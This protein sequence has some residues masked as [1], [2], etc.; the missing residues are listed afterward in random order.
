MLMPLP[1]LPPNFFPTGMAL[2]L[3]I[4]LGSVP[5][6]Q[7]A[8]VALASAINNGNGGTFNL[9]PADVY[10]GSASISAA[11]VINANG[12]II[13]FANG[14]DLQVN[15][16]TLTVNNAA[17]QFS[18]GASTGFAVNFAAPA[19]GQMNSC[20]FTGF[21][22]AV[23][24][25][26]ASAIAPVFQG[27][28]FTSNN[29]ALFIGGATRPVA[30]GCTFTNNG[31][32]VQASGTSAP[33]I[34][35]CTFTNTSPAIARRGIQA[36][37]G[38]Y[39]SGQTRI[40]GNTF[41]N[42]GGSGAPVIDLLGTAHPIIEGNSFSYNN[43]QADTWF[44]QARDSAPHI[45]GNRFQ[46]GGR[47]IVIQGV[48]SFPAGGAL[49]PDRRP[50]EGNVF[51]QQTVTSVQF[52]SSEAA[53]A[54]YVTGNTFYNTIQGISLRNVTNTV[55]ISRNTF[56]SYAI[57][58]GNLANSQGVASGI[59]VG[60]SVRTRI[61]ENAVKG[62]YIGIHITDNASADVWGNVV[63]ENWGG[64]IIMDRGATADVAYNTLRKN[65]ADNIYYG[66]SSGTVWGNRCYDG[67]RWPGIT[68]GATGIAAELNS[69]VV[70]LDNLT[71]NNLDQGIAII[72]ASQA[73]LIAGNMSVNEGRAGILVGGGTNV[74]AVADNLTLGSPQGI[75]TSVLVG[76]ETAPNTVFWGNALLDATDF[77]ALFN[78]GGSLMR[79]YNP[80]IHTGIRGIG[81]TRGGRLTVRGGII[82]GI[83]GAGGI[84]THFVSND[85][86]IS[87]LLDNTM[88]GPAAG[89]H[90]SNSSAGFN[91]SSTRDWWGAANGPNPPGS[92]F[93]VQRLTVTTPV[94][95]P[96][97]DI[98]R[99]SPLSWASGATTNYTASF[100][101]LQNVQGSQEIRFSS[102]PSL[103]G[104][105]RPF[106]A[107]R[108]AVLAYDAPLL[109][110]AG[111]PL[112]YQV[113]IPFEYWFEAS[114]FSILFPIEPGRVP[115]GFTTDDARLYWHDA[116]AG[117]WRA[118]A[119]DVVL[120]GTFA[121]LRAP[122]LRN[123]SGTYFI[124]FDKNR[125]RT[126]TV[127]TSG[128]GG[129]VVLA[130]TGA[131]LVNGQAYTFLDG[132]S[133]RLRARGSLS[134]FQS[135][136]GGASGT[137][138]LIE[139][140]MTQNRSIV[141]NFT[142]ASA[143]ALNEPN[144]DFATATT[145]D[146]RGL[147]AYT[148]PTR[149]TVGLG[150]DSD[151]WY[152]I[153]LDPRSHMTAFLDTKSDDA[154]LHL[155]LWDRRS[156][157][158]AEWGTQLGENY[159]RADVKDIPY[160]NLTNPTEL[161]LRVYPNGATDGT[162]YGLSFTM[163]G[164]DDIHDLAGRNNDEPQHQLPTLTP[165]STTTGLIC[166]DEDW[167]RIELGGLDITHLDIR[168]EHVFA[169]GDLHMMLT[170]DAG[171]NSW[172]QII[173]GAYST[174]SQSDFEEMRG[175]FVG[176]RQTVLLRVYGTNRQTN[177]YRLIIADSRIGTATMATVPTKPA[178]YVAGG[179]AAPSIKPIATDPVEALPDKHNG[180]SIPRATIDGAVPVTVASGTVAV[181]SQTLSEE[182]WYRLDL[183][184]LAH[185]RIQ[186]TFA[187]AQGNINMQLYDR[188]S[189]LPSTGEWGHRVG[190]SYTVG[191]GEII[192][193][194]NL[195]DPASLYLRVYG[196][197]GNTGQTFSFTVQR[198]DTDDAL[199]L[200]NDSPCAPTSIALNTTYTNL[201]CKDEDW[202]E[203][204]VTGLNTITVRADFST[205]SGD[206]HLM[207]AAPP[208]GQCAN[209]FAH[210]IAGSYSTS[211]AEDFEQLTTP[212][213]GGRSTVLV[214]VFGATR[215]TNMYSLRVTA[216]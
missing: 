156:S 22:R 133:V 191:N 40:F 137:S 30:D 158:G 34:Q 145:I 132:E 77:S 109:A 55:E 81:L 123:P 17:F 147:S 138:S 19:S 119:S 154:L 121:S 43:T 45:K 71:E 14:Q 63:D 102:R 211:A 180:L 167:F 176:G 11:T 106:V 169:S 35:G 72:N 4:L 160:A 48:G 66:Q 41:T 214:R 196:E 74:G 175:V 210:I 197:N 183:P 12:A 82:T 139:V 161:F 28:T 181:N 194:V 162:D 36:T 26:G 206:L 97:A 23:Q 54:S 9:N 107:S 118:Q 155:Q 213:L 2:C 115:A 170:E 69:N 144:N 58:V 5:S 174:D 207:V 173:Q 204:P 65:L 29:V 187:H 208:S 148:F 136:G 91:S 103:A 84:A 70:I 141:A 50:I 105:N 215:Q 186:A 129:A 85:N 198:T 51:R 24:V 44:I 159:A 116:A 171:T 20:S 39:A 93:T 122:S 114:D 60:E 201:V 49:S 199:E 86:S 163:V 57:N 188:R 177:H 117:A 64:G 79:L 59:T 68:S 73:R 1:Q 98:V 101:L 216:P 88:L 89:G 42:I 150:G 96:L 189:A 25:N 152:R 166:R 153:L 87:T 205:N 112:F 113:H 32:A 61:L 16:A 179:I 21:D 143:N 78:A 75:T 202:Y 38:T 185:I 18:G 99:S 3:L 165:G 53:R 184:R 6:I 149:P 100:G 125:R 212:S 104:T 135:W 80:I 67:G 203:V 52:G 110:N 10:V 46:G 108:Q 37:T 195:S 33:A 164:G 111:S 62:H 7:A 130:D 209:P 146:L 27:C 95:S 140:A 124:G 178:R 13:R 31:L 172:G 83:S 142:A 190:E 182:R 200:N 76:G 56:R 47:G 168:A 8:D 94:N 192:T 131:T 128:A 92:G 126:L 151:D 15:A 127:T 120:G 193:Y 90:F 157:S 134:R